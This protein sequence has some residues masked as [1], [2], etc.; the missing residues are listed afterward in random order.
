MTHSPRLTHLA[1]AFVT[2]QS[3]LTPVKRN[4]T[5]EDGKRYADMAAIRKHVQRRL[6]N[7]GL[8]VVQFA[9]FDK[10]ETVILHSSGQWIAHETNLTTIGGDLAYGPRYGLM[11]A[12][13]VVQEQQE[14]TTV[15]AVA[16]RL[17]ATDTTAACELMRTLGLS[18]GQ[19]TV[20]LKKYSD[21]DGLKAEAEKM[22]G[23]K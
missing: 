8:S 22:A 21:L 20:L 15:V 16:T 17:S 4:A 3:T 13:G 19:Q 18:I 2:F 12:L 9:G 11:M 5:G 6:W 7:N 1:D 23:A 10:V 14:E